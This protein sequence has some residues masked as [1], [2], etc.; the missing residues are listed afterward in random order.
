MSRKSRRREAAEPA[1]PGAKSVRAVTV[2]S[3]PSGV[4]FEVVVGCGAILAAPTILAYLNGDMG[5]DATVLRLMVALAV[6]WVLTTL[7]LAVY[8]II[9]G[10]PRPDVVVGVE[11]TTGILPGRVPGM[12]PAGP[13]P[14]VPPMPAAGQDPQ[15]PPGG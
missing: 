14:G 2:D 15:P 6:A 5:F 7:V 4:P 11:Q 13:P 3:G 9:R 1:P 8:R 10:A 12:P